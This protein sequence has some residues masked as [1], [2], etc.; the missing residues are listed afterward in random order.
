VEFFTR[1]Q[2]SGSLQQGS[3][4]NDVAARKEQYYVDSSRA[5][6]DSGRLAGGVTEHQQSSNSI[7]SPQDPSTNRRPRNRDINISRSQTSDPQ[8]ST[9]PDSE[10]TVYFQTLPV[11]YTNNPFFQRFLLRTT[12]STPQWSTDTSLPSEPQN[13][14]GE[15]TEMKI[16]RGENVELREAT[17]TRVLHTHALSQ[18]LSPGKASDLAFA[19][20]VPEVANFETSL[21][22]QEV[23]ETHVNKALLQSITKAN[24]LPLPV[25]VFPPN[26]EQKSP[27][28]NV[29]FG[30][31]ADKSGN[32]VQLH[33]PDIR[34]VFFIPDSD[35]DVGGPS[36]Y[37]RQ[38]GNTTLLSISVPEMS[39][40]MHFRNNIEATAGHNI[41]CPRCY[42]GFLVPG[43]CHPCVI[44]R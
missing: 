3:L 32:T 27:Q 40:F 28:T 39:Q 17:G 29:N 12:P 20:E 30:E 31:T 19:L 9:P 42:P 24:A 6:A 34:R 7:T 21:T 44:I 26:F 5:L 38:T 14:S 23:S 25:P 33:L 35:E 10:T 2:T 4:F 41:D 18:H 16:F 22:Q 43:S 37:D 11:A 8:I 13:S 36:S 15:L 1:R